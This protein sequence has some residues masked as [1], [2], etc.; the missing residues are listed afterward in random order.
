MGNVCGAVG[1]RCSTNSNPNYAIPGELNSSQPISLT[2][3]RPQ[4]TVDRGVKRLPLVCLPAE[5][6]ALQL[7]QPWLCAT[8][9]SSAGL[10]GPASTSCTTT[11]MLRLQ[12]W[13][14]LGQLDLT[15]L[16]I[17]LRAEKSPILLEG[18]GQ[19]TSSLTAYT[20]AIRGPATPLRVLVPPQAG[21]RGEGAGSR[22]TP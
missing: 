17:R 11:L 20:D 15:S 2:P 6:E 13:L 16:T 12:R 18:K 5:D 1:L 8:G 3:P 22:V 19:T 10:S 21:K 4:P 7:G 14:Q 9:S